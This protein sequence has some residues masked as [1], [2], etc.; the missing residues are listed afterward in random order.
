MKLQH[1]NVLGTLTNISKQA[2][3]R[4]L[5]Q[6]SSRKASRG[7]RQEGSLSH[8]ESNDMIEEEMQKADG[9][10]F[11]SAVVAGRDAKGR[12][13]T[14]EDAEG[15]VH[16][17]FPA[18][19]EE[20]DEPDWED[21]SVSISDVRENLSNN[22]EREVTVEFSK[23]PSSAKRKVIRRASVEDKELAEL[24]HKVHLLC[25]VGRGRLVDRACDDPLIQ[26]SLLSLVPTQLQDMVKVP[27]MKANA[28]TALVD[29]FHGNFH[30]R[31]ASSSERSFTS[32]MAYALET[33]EGT[34]EEVAALSVALFRALNLTARF[35]SILDVASLKPEADL[36]ECSNQDINKVDTRIFSKGLASSNHIS[37]VYPGQSSSQK[38]N[39]NGAIG[40]ESPQRCGQQ[41]RESDLT[42]KSNKSKSLLVTCQM[43]DQTSDS[44]ASNAC[45][46]SNEVLATDHDKGSKRKGDVEFELQL[47]MALA[48]T[49]AGACESTLDLDSKDVNG[50]SSK[51]TSPFKIVKRIKS[52]DS[53]VSAK[54][55][56]GAVWSRKAGPLMYWAEVFCCGETLTGRWVHVDAA[57]A[58]IDGEQKVEAAAAVCRK[59][60]RYVVAFA[61]NGAKDVTRRYCMKWYTIA[62][63]RVN[64]QWW[65]QVLVPL[66]QLES[67]ATEGVVPLEMQLENA[68]SELH[69]LKAVKVS[70]SLEV[71]SNET[72]G[73]SSARE[74]LPSLTQVFGIEASKLLGM[75]IDVKSPIQSPGVG[76]RSSL[77]DMELETR[78]LTE[79]LPTNQLAYKNHQLYAIERWLTRYQILH[80][81]GPILGYCSGHPVY[82]RTCVQTL[83]TKHRWLREGLQVKEN[84]CP[85][86]VV[87]RSQ[88]SKMSSEPS[89]SEEDDGEGTIELYGKWQMEPLQLPHAV[90]G[91]VPKNERGQVD[92]WSEKCLPPGTV[93]LRLPRLVPVVKRL[94]IDFA[95]AMVGFEF[96]NGRSLPIFEGLVVCT[97]F[98]HAIMEAYAEEEERRQAQEKKWNESQALSRWYQLISNMVTRRRLKNSYE[99]GSTSQ[100]HHNLLH[101]KDDQCMAQICDHRG[102]DLSGEFH[103]EYVQDH[104][105]SALDYRPAA[106]FASD[107]EHV[108]PVENQSFDEESSVRTKWCPCGFSIQVEEM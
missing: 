42:C 104:G 41:I 23:S 47:E 69:K 65:G 32:S 98:K 108:F 76:S 27:K 82:P 61:G 103:Q 105:G 62:S 48:A 14:G 91:I 59:S 12:T 58:I 102:S 33:R 15:I 80:P 5:R 46:D 25:L 4:F 101:Q 3:G 63:Q 60:L 44:I 17:S 83:Q 29:W 6:G 100:A 77:E 37:A 26:A 75:N 68:S 36:P 74:H 13:P 53:P 30:V 81:K 34:A 95:P 50:S 35:V 71:Y 55:S 52:E 79:P 21:G 86:K 96:R 66:K 106:A 20:T 56:S 88:K 49:A 24:V 87:K 107:H 31:N 64:S 73:S 28:L 51:I 38:T 93:H 45:N 97:E 85:A 92:V 67:G 40:H 11:S 8:G 72:A 19:T 94:E 70:D 10:L 57:N 22:L 90:N 7:K 84:E 18:K 2:V 9:E 1:E 39:T 54:G 99:V 43:N 16:H 89:I 78:A